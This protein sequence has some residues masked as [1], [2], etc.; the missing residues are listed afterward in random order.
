M[1]VIGLVVIV[2]L[3]TLGMLFMAKFALDE[4]DKKSTF[5]SEGLAVSTMAA[6]MKLSVNCRQPGDS[7]L[8]LQNDLLESCVEN[9]GL[10]QPQCNGVDVC[11]FLNQTIKDLLNQTLGVWG[12]SYQF[13]SK[14]F[15]GDKPDPILSIVDDDGKGC[16][17][18]DRDTSRLFPLSTD[19]GIVQSV[20]YVCD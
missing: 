13:E 19:Q 6:M 11:D 12:K 4:K 15:S 7:Y 16:G 17:K 1:E 2:I 14:L 20:L 9:V 18:V 3:I 5:T 10:T 8:A